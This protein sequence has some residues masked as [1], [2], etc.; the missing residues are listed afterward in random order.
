MNSYSAKHQY[1]AELEE[2]LD[3]FSF[4]ELLER[5]SITE[6]EVLELLLLHGYFT[7]DDLRRQTESET[8]ETDEKIDTE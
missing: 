5:V 8:E 2:L 6:L 4:E 3:I 1:F 7:I